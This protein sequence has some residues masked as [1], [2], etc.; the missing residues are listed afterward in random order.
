MTWDV[1]TPLGTISVAANKSK[2]QNNFTYIETQEQKDH[3]FDNAN[4][5]YDGHHQKIEMPSNSSVP[6]LSTDMSTGVTTINRTYTVDNIATTNSIAAY[7]GKFKDITTG[8]SH[9]FQFLPVLAWATF[10]QSGTTVGTTNS[11][12]IT[13][14]VR[15]S[16]G[17]YTVTFT[18]A[19]PSDRYMV[20][21]SAIAN[22]GSSNCFLGYQ[23]TNTYTDR[24]T[25][26]TVTIQVSGNNNDNAEPS[27]VSFIVLGY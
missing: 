18:D 12:N 19:L 21:G 23:K 1:N 25:V 20:T 6:A 22:A 14:I 17:N 11:F 10:S 16:V 9:P 27:F 5:N 7:E 3:F 2:F 15:N 24:Q 4:T 8:V 26:S 13:S